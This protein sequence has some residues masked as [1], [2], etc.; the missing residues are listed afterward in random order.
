MTPVSANEATIA[1]APAPTWSSIA[2]TWWVAPT[3]IALAVGTLIRFGFSAGAVLWT[4]VQ[5]VLVGL[6]AYDLA[7]RRLPNLVTVPVSL[8]AIGARGAFERSALVEVIVAGVV[9]FGV[10]LLLAL[11]L[12]GGLGMGDVKLAGMLGFLL[13]RAVAPALLIGVF[14]GGILA[15][16][17]LIGSAA[18]R[19]STI[20]Y[21]PYLAL[22]GAVAILAFNPPP[23]V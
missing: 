1:S 6:A 15:A 17:L 11:L 20:A 13:G 18:N 7:T 23:L 21:G 12:R 3:A 8:L 10:F 16:A 9:A 19:R 14:A 5:I 4:L 2:S 22:G